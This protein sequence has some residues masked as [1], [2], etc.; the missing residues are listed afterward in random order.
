M[1]YSTT[2]SP[3]MYIGSTGID[4]LHHL[5]YEVVDNSVDEALAG[6]CTDIWVT[7]HTDNSITVK[8]NGR[9]IPTGMHEKLKKSALEVVMT[10]LNAG[11]KFDKKSY[12]VSAGLH[13]VEKKPMPYLLGT[14]NLILHGI[15]AP[16]IAHTNTL[17]VNLNDVQDKDRVDVIL[18]NPPYVRHHHLEREDKERLQALTH[19]MT[20]V[21][22]NGLAGLLPVLAAQGLPLVQRG[23]YEGGR[24]A[25]LTGSPDETYYTDKSAMWGGTSGAMQVVDLEDPGAPKLVT[26]WHLPGQRARKGTRWPPSHSPIF[27]PCIPA[28]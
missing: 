28:L 7:M 27:R 12:K 5:V 22:V 11:A 26:T 17:G 4:G 23:D 1:P 6:H 19:R 9:G 20:G 21:E 10:M 18:A 2:T 14:M 15:E 3:A 25:Y 8:D 24:Y 16:N 13:G